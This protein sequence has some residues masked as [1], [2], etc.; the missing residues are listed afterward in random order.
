MDTSG[1]SQLD[2]S[3]NDS[4]TDSE[5]TNDDSSSPNPS[6]VHKKHTRTQTGKKK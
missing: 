2:R 1:S 6:Q 5:N 3:V 4:M